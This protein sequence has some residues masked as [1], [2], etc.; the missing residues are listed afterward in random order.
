MLIPM[1]I[2]DDGRIDMLVQRCFDKPPDGFCNI[3]AIYNNVIFDSFFIKAMM[4]SQTNSDQEDLGQ[5]MFGANIAGA[6]FRYIVTTLEDQ[7][8]VRVATQAPQTSYNSLELPYSHNGIGRSNNYLESFNV[9]YSHHSGQNQVRVFTPIIPNS[10]L[11]ITANDVDAK[12]WNL[13]L[14][15]SPMEYLIVIVFA[16]SAVLVVSGVIIVIM[17]W[18][19]KKEDNKN[20]LQIDF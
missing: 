8:Y 14:F 18:Q 4:L 15:V 12:S 1:D 6:T 10:Q 7:K 5:K 20:R 9:A 3:T 17:H 11:I 2:D 13:D 16:A 19:E